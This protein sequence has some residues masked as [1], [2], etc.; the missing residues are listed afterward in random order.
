ML[1]IIK[2]MSLSMKVLAFGV[3][4]AIALFGVVINIA[5][6]H[7]DPGGCS[8]TGPALLLG[9]FTV[10]GTTPVFSASPG[11]TIYYK[12]TLT[13]VGP[14]QCNYGGGDLDI[15]LPNSTSVDVDGGLVPLVSFGVPFNSALAPYVVNS[16][17]VGIDGDL[18]ASAIYAEGTSHF[19]DND[20]TPVGATTPTATPFVKLDSTTVTQ[21]HDASE[22]VVTSVVAGSTVHDKATVSPATSGPI[23]TGDV[24]FVFYTGS[25]QCTGDSVAS[26]TDIPLVAG[27]AHP[28]SSQGPLVPGFYSFQA[29]YSGDADYNSSVGACEP[30][31]VVAARI[32]IGTTDTNVVN[33][34]HTFTVTVERN[35]GTGWIAASNEDVAESEI[36]IGSITGGT[37]T[38]GNTNISGQCTIIVSSAT[39]GQSTVNASAVVG[40][41]NINIAVATD[42]N[43]AFNISNIKTWVD[44]RITISQSGTNPVNSPHTFTVFVEK[45]DGIVGWVDASGVTISSSITG[46]G[47]ITGGTCGPSGPTDVNGE[48]TVQINSPTPGVGTVNA[49]GTVNVGGLNV[50]VATTG[51]GAHD[52]STQKTWVAGSIVIIKN[53]VPDDET[54]FAFT[55]NTLPDGA[56]SL[57]DDGDNVDELSNTKTYSGLVPGA[58]DVAETANP[59]YSTVSDCD[60]TEQGDQSTP[61]AIDLDAGETVTCTFTN[62]LNGGRIEIE[63]QTTPA[64]SAQSFGFTGEIVTSLVDNGVEGK[65]VVAGQYSVTEGATTGWTLSSIVCNDQNSSG[66][67]STANFTVEPGETVRCVFNNTENPGHIIIVKQT[68]PDGNPQSFEF[69]PSY[70]NNFNLTDGN[71]NDSGALA[72]G[73]YS[74]AEVNLP[75]NWSLSSATCSDQSPVNNIQ[76]EAGETVTCT[77]TN[78]F[79]PPA[80]QGCSPGYWKQDQHFDSY[81]IYGP[82]DLFDT[83]FDETVFPGMTLVDVLSQGGGGINALGRIITGALLNADSIPDY[84]GTAGDVISDFQ[85]VF[86]GTKD[87]YNALKAEYE[88]LQDPCPL[89]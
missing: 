22:A 1:S 65:D 19:G 43:G 86:P 23:P 3:L 66:N 48:C 76:L 88:A 69:D 41:G 12:A 17:D 80:T 15:T 20:V 83:V 38:I 10:D 39:P 32:S 42:G 75:A 81:N 24:D 84:P 58:Y 67:G 4:V 29:S 85:G 68:N 63:K 30:L 46:T 36:C 44:A 56:F 52:I 8:S 21:I 53:P 59:A 51:Y 45:N 79:T 6:A 64:G 87:A 78:A 27:I 61:G 47:S 26:G 31:S 18:D 50:A 60:S 5:N 62:T 13:H 57:E 34:P 49:G 37:C 11:D 40:I 9:V 35:D 77:F 7:S 28:S 54:D 74:V 2:N 70:G 82:T 14:P 55:T 16:A 73:A 72:A 33:D 89:N 71:Q 25:S